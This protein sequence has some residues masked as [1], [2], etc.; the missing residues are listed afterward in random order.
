MCSGTV[1]WANIGRVVFGMT[2]ARLLE[3]TGDHAENPT[4]SV[5]SR[6]V[7]DLGQK[8]IN[9]MRYLITCQKI[10]STAT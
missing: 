10:A 7:F 9:L 3:S 4:M 1:Y 5:S 2:E 8:K 6:F